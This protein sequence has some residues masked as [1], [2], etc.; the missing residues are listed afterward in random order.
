MKSSNM[1]ALVCRSHTLPDFF[2]NAIFTILTVDM[3]LM[4]LSPMHKRS[5]EAIASG[6]VRQLQVLATVLNRTGCL[7]DRF[8]MLMHGLTRTGDTDAHSHSD[9]SL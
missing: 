1:S 6:Q 2:N 8:L 4:L 7:H 5:N 9:V 3:F